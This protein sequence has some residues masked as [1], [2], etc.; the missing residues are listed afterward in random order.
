MGRLELNRG[1]AL[2]FG[3]ALPLLQA[4]RTICFDR[5][6]PE[7]LARWP[8]ALDA[9]VMGGLLLAGGLLAVRSFAGQILLAAGWGFSSGIL[10]RSFFEH[11]ADP[12]RQASTHLLV[13]VVK[14]ILL[15]WSLGGLLG[16][17]LAMHRAPEP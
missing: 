7:S 11:L 5:G 6:W 10:Y 16:C 9:Y 17:V 3:V 4:G 14:A 13:L 1:A 15:A 2:A 8:I 12:T